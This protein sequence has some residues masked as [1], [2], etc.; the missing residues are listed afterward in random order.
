MESAAKTSKDKDPGED[1][2]TEDCGD[3]E[4]DKNTKWNEKSLAATSILK[5]V[6]V[7]Y[8]VGIWTLQYCCISNNWQI[9][10]KIYSKK[11]MWQAY[12]HSQTS[13]LVLVFKALTKATKSW[14]GKEKSAGI[15][16]EIGLR[17]KK[18]EMYRNSQLLWEHMKRRVLK[19]VKRIGEGHRA[20]NIL[21]VSLQ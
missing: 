11:P 2:K 6:N 9:S 17:E 10:S 7:L 14:F 3:A 18:N 20:Q 5:C 19:L 21:Q 15:E 8:S 16:P 4:C 13:T 12:K 1:E